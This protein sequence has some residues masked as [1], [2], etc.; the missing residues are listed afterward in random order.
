VSAFS[1]E[2]YNMKHISSADNQEIKNLVKLHT[3]KERR[4]QKSFLTEGIRC[5]QTFWQA[6]T[7]LQQIFV[8]ERECDAVLALGFEEE[9]ITVIPD[10]LM[11]KISQASTP[12]G[13]VGQFALPQHPASEHLAPGLVLAHIQDPG[14]MGTLIRTAVAL[15]IKSILILNGSTDP[16]SYKVIQASAGALAHAHVY[17]TNW[18]QL[19]AY[20]KESITIGLVSTGGKTPQEIISLPGIHN[21][22]I[23]VGNEA[24]GLT[25]EQEE[26][27]DFLMTLPMPSGNAESLNAAIAGA[28]ALY[29]IHAPL[30]T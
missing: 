26:Q 18:S 16:W 6:G 3:S 23:V 15:D 11:R 10:Q 2:I 25:Q 9:K 29:L 12:S 1:W 14:N 24:H 8:T 4:L 28:L 30:K 13:I 17:E 7:L 20:K 21:S 5:T 27:C 19:M 22:L